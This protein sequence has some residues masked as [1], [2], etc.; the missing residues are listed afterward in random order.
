[1]QAAC[2]EERIISQRGLSRSLSSVILG[3]YCRKRRFNISDSR[4]LRSCFSPPVDQCLRDGIERMKP[5]T[6][7]G[8]FRSLDDT[9]CSNALMRTI[10]SAM[11]KGFSGNRLPPVSKPSTTSLAAE[12]ADRMG[13]RFVRI[14]LTDQFDHRKSHPSWA[15]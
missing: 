1:M 8:G 2:V 13:Q 9:L 14:R 6:E 11:P 15:S 3:P 7:R 5:D 4:L 10:N 12:R